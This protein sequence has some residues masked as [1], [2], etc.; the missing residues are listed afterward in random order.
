MQLRYY[1][2]VISQGD[3]S[4]PHLSIKINY[5]KGNNGSANIH[6]IMPLGISKEKNNFIY[7][8]EVE[9]K[10]SH[11]FDKR[12]VA[13]NRYVYYLVGKN[14]MGALVKDPIIKNMENALK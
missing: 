12:Y 5:R 6:H 8:N 3:Y 4:L 7:H 2:F 13:G 14:F 1:N 9:S 10:K 11:N